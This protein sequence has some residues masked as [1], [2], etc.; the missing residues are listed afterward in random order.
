MPIRNAKVP[1][2]LFYYLVSTDEQCLRQ[3]KS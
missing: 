3:G 1:E 2:G